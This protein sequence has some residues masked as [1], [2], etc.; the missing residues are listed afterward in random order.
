MDYAGGHYGGGAAADEGLGDLG[1]GFLGGEGER[2][3][4]EHLTMENLVGLVAGGG[5]GASWGRVRER[6]GEA[7]GRGVDV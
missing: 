3:G 6:E 2:V 1:D 7:F 5:E 4:G